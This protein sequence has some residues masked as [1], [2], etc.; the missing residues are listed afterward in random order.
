LVVPMEN[1]GGGSFVDVKSKDFP[2]TVGGNL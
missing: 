2:V 1:V